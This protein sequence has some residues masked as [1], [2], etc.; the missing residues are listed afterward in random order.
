MVQYVTLSNCGKAK[1]ELG[2]YVPSKSEVE[3]SI[4]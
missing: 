4:L 3:N 1:G 2:T